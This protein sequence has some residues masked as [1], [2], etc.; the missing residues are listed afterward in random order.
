MARP[1]DWSEM[2]QRIEALLERRTGAGV[3]E[4]NRR[5]RASG[6]DGDE[7]SLRAWLTAQGVTGYGQMLMVMERF[8]YPD[9][10]TASA[11]ELVDAQ[12][13]DRAELRPIFEQ[14][15]MLAESLGE[16]S[17]QARKTYVAL[18]TPRRTFAVV[19]ATTRK[20]VDLG[21]RLG[22]E[23]RPG[24]LLPAPGVGND[25]ITARIPLAT[26]DDV[27]D[28]VAELLELAYRESA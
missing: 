21:L 8:G 18:V 9:F 7:A 6:A 13:A 5:V 16:V 25:A 22:P 17:V 19:Q 20:R 15:V 10:F 11:D 28:E 4:W 3:E 12:Y 14:V 1:K 2:R 24:R 23:R 27:D 26:P